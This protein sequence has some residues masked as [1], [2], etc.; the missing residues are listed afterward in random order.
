[1]TTSNASDISVSAEKSQSTEMGHLK[2][3]DVQLTSGFL[4]IICS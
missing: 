1:M 4:T 3:V 2:N